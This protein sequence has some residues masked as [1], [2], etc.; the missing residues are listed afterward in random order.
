MDA[1]KPPKEAPSPEERRTAWLRRQLADA[2]ERDDA[3]YDRIHRICNPQA[4]PPAILM[5]H[6]EP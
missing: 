6:G 1:C 2:P 3:W 4:P 5:S